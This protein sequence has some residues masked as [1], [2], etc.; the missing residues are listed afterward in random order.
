MYTHRG[1]QLILMTIAE[2]AV[3]TIMIYLVVH[4]VRLCC[5][6]QCG[7]R[8]L[9]TCVSYESMYQNFDRDYLSPDALKQWQT[10]DYHVK[11]S[12]SEVEIKFAKQTSFDKFKRMLLY[13]YPTLPWSKYLQ[14][15]CAQIR[16]ESGK[17]VT[18]HLWEDI[19]SVWLSGDGKKDWYNK[20][21][22]ELYADAVYGQIPGDT[23]NI[24][25]P[26]S[27][28]SSGR[29]SRTSG[30]RL[31]RGCSLVEIPATYTVKNLE[32]GGMEIEFP[33]SDFV[34]EMKSVI[35]SSRTG[36]S[37]SEMVKWSGHS[38]KVKTDTGKSVV[39]QVGSQ[40]EASRKIWLYNDPACKDW[41]NK[42]FKRL[43]AMVYENIHK[44]DC[45]SGRSMTESEATIAPVEHT[46]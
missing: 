3:N 30:K 27:A 11:I 2:N 43:Y 28:T 10:G 44:M 14:R 17:N 22:Q 25:R 35:E 13:R 40:T 31:S 12:Q 8:D 20:E 21:F 19:R 34:C 16:L 15:D 41:F 37:K 46:A 29:L 7:E 33:S 6:W 45:S 18:V 9:R 4:L 32:N 36:L 5:R 23:I 24:S 39:I 1:N 26:H 38:A 42:H